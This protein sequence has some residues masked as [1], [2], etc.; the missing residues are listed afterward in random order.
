MNWKSWA[1]LTGIVFVVLL[2]VG[3]IV[4]GEP[5]D[6]DSPAQEIVAHYSDDKDSVIAG[7]ILIGLA[8]V[9]LLFFAG[10]LRSALRRA[11]GEGGV[12]SAVALVGG[13]VFAVGI[14]LDATISVALAETVDDIEPS[15]VQALQAL[16]EYGFVPGTV[17]A[18]VLLVSSGISIVRHG[19][20]PQWLGWVAIVLG[21]AFATTFFIAFLL[22]GIWILVVSV[23]LAMRAGAATA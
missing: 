14:A 22:A 12:L 3:V 8:P 21:V 23:V 10:S 2:V 6:L 17:G 20:L 1:P 13:A 11:E 9:F 16:L 19:A 15:A 7:S 4:R 5:P 18:V